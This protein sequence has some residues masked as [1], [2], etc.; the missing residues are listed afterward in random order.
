MVSPEF[1]F[2]MRGR[3]GSEHPRGYSAEKRNEI[4]EFMRRQEGGLHFGRAGERF[5]VS[6]ETVGRWWREYLAERA[7]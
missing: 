4:I 5:G 6:R 2:S 7:A 3:R 1:V